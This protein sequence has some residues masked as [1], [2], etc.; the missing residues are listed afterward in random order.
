MLDELPAVL[1]QPGFVWVDLGDPAPGETEVLHHPALRL[2]PRVLEDMLDDQHLP[3]L[4]AEDDVLSLTVHG[5]A[6][7]TVELEIQTRELDVA[8]SQR[9]IVTFHVKP[10]ASVTA[11]GDR[12]DRVGANGITR[13][14]Q[15]LHR[16]LDVMTDVFLPFL[17]LM[18]KR[19]DV[20][21]DDL[22]DDPGDHTRRDI[23]ALQ[24]DVIQLRRAV[25]PQAE[26]IRRLGRDPIGLL[27]SEDAAAFR[28]VYDHLHRL[29]ALSDS[30]R[31]LLDSAMSSYRSAQ[32]GKLNEMLRVLT[33]VSAVLLPLTVIAGIY[34]TNF[35]YLPELAYRWAYP[36]MWGLFIII[37]GAQLT[38]FRHRGWIGSRAKK[39]A[40]HRRR[41]SLGDVMEIPLLGQ[42]M[43]V[44]VAGAR[45]VTATGRQV[46]R[47]AG[48][49]ARVSHHAAPEPD[50][51]PDQQLGDDDTSRL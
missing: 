50:R 10:L 33:L 32:D 6:L 46:R 34:G 44:P 27:T 13:P 1:K 31:Q 49:I 3:K 23:Y 29:A 19:L 40:D 18:E 14:A 8:A 12:L 35:A 26:V 39:A 22:L 51:N 30:Y 25:V 28:D 24:R 15:L 45:V 42:V 17:D 2:P 4:D 48:A 20:I 43:R 38:W 47:G 5:M 7:D 36:A 9:M 37:V 21:E 41:V 11:L 16:L